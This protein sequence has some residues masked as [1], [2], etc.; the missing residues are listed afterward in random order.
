MYQ[1]LDSIQSYPNLNSNLYQISEV[2]IKD[3]TVLLTR[4][5]LFQIES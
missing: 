5:K 4:F 1:K 3:W 2:R